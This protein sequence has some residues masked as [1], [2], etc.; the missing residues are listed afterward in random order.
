MHTLQVAHMAP[1]V[2]RRMTFIHKLNL[3]VHGVLERQ[4]RLYEWL[5]HHLQDLLDSIGIL[6][7]GH[8]PLLLFPPTVLQNITAN[9]IQMV[10]K[11]YP[12]YAL[13]IEHITEY[14]DIKLATFS[15][16]SGGSMV[17][18]F[19]V[20]VKDHASKPKT[21]YEIEMVKVPIPD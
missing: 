5:L 3:Y 4:I 2:V 16:D 18:A 10:C 19:P 11:M 21:L 14:Y 13:A 1:D 20:F 17:V 8:L 6:S 12:D 9:A 7:T 15:P